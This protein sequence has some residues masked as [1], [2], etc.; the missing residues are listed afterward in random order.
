VN[1]YLL[2]SNFLI[3]YTVKEYF[4]EINLE[5]IEIKKLLRQVNLKVDS[6]DSE[7]ARLL[8]FSL[9]HLGDL[10]EFLTD[11]IKEQY[12]TEMWFTLENLGKSIRH[13]E[14]KFKTIGKIL[15][16]KDFS[17]FEQLIISI[18]E[19]EHYDFTELEEMEKRKK[20]YNLKN[21]YDET[22]PYICDE[23]PLR[24]LVIPE[25]SRE[26]SKKYGRF[27]IKQVTYGSEENEDEEFS[28]NEFLCFEKD[29][30]WIDVHYTTLKEREFDYEH[31]RVRNRS[32]SSYLR[33]I[34]VDIEDLVFYIEDESGVLYC[35]VTKTAW[36]RYNVGPTKRPY[37][38]RIGKLR[39]FKLPN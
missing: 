31:G 7:I 9:I 14:M 35:S 24:E 5:L 12:P 20:K 11:D 1:L 19:K 29:G 17:A 8:E 21:S 34:Y 3:K 2:E 32:G 6:R 16:S 23:K 30:E 13:N 15:N 4:F 37:Y 36:Y 26:E 28:S 27:K 10:I 39:K 33:V 18:I 25:I 38:N 22:N